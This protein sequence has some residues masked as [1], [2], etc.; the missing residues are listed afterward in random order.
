VL[1]LLLLLLLAAYSMYFTAFFLKIALVVCAGLGSHWRRTRVYLRALA[2]P[3]WP[4]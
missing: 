3:R 1:Q 2:R 4:L